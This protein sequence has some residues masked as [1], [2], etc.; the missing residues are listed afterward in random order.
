MEVEHMKNAKD[1]LGMAY[2]IDQR[3]ESKID[4]VD[5]LN[6]LATKATSTISDMPGSA[7]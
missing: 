5:S 1:Y 2:K 3:I 7:T 6:A 4:Q